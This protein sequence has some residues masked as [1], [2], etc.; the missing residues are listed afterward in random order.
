MEIGFVAQAAQATGH[1]LVGEPGTGKTSLARG[2][3]SRAAQSFPKD[4]F[5]YVEV[6]PHPAALTRENALDI[7][8][9][10]DVVVDGTDNFETRYLTNDACFFRLQK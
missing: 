2:L 7:L 10:Y 9:R 3:A 1:L 4:E 5:R 8:G 6:E